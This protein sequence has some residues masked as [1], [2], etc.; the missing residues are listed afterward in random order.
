VREPLLP[1]VVAFLVC[2]A[3]RTLAQKSTATVADKPQ[4]H[5]KRWLMPTAAEDAASNLL[6]LG[7][8]TTSMAVIGWIS[9]A[10]A[11]QLRGRPGAV[12]SASFLC[13]TSKSIQ[14]VTFTQRPRNLSRN[15]RVDQS[16]P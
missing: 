11:L 8:C 12:F 5:L 14:P 10:V 3:W 4:P 1:L 6:Y 13:S 16:M 2:F 15:A 9:H 7:L